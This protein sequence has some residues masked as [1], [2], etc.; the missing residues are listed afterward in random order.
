M[1]WMI[2]SPTMT[3]RAGLD[4]CARTIVN[5]SP[6]AGVILTIS[7]LVGSGLDPGKM[8]ALPEVNREPCPAVTVNVVP[9]VA[10]DGAVATADRVK[11]LLANVSPYASEM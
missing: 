7:A 9:D 5:T 1:L 3:D 8:T 10:G 2:V 11:F 4:S 6:P